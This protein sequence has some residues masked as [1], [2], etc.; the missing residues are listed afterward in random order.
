MLF[1]FLL[2]ERLLHFILNFRDDISPAKTA[3]GL[4]TRDLIHRAGISPRRRDPRGLPSAEWP[5]ACPN[6]SC[7]RANMTG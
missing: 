3:C 5:E 4:T 7:K 2:F 1:F 6:L